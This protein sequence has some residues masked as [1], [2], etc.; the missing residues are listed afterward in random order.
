MKQIV[1][2]AAN[3]ELDRLGQRFGQTLAVIEEA[4]KARV[5]HV[6]K[7]GETVDLGPDHYARL[8]AGG[9]LIKLMTPGSPI[10]KLKDATEGRR[11]MTLVELERRVGKE[12]PRA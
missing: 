8:T 3:S 1:V 9:V 10:P 5:L 7:N 6:G 11:G 12:E 2:A 4:F